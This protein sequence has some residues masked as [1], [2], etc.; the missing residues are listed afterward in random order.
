MAFVIALFVIV[1]V[2]TLL[3]EVMYWKSLFQLII[4][5]I[6]LLKNK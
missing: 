1:L 4:S 6:K 3:I 2:I 5:I